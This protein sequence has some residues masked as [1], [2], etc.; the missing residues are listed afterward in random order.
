MLSITRQFIKPNVILSKTTFMSTLTKAPSVKFNKDNLITTKSDNT[1]IGQ[2]NKDAKLKKYIGNVY[3]YSGWGFTGSLATAVGA[4]VATAS[5]LTVAPTATI[6]LG[7]AWLGN[8]GYSFYTLFQIGKQNS[9][10]TNTM[11]EII[12]EKKLTNYKLFCISNGITIAPLVGV[13]YLVN[14]MIV[15][16]A[17]TSTIG[18]FAGATYYALKQKDLNAITWQAPLMGCVTGL[19]GSSLVQIGASLAGYSTFAHNLDIISTLI[20]TGVFTGL[21]VADTQQAIKDFESKSLDSINCSVNLL[22]DATN[23]FI[24]FIKIFTELMKSIKE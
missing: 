5:I 11:D 9:E 18:T 21:I 2:I 22:L 13:S 4:S 8:V 19:I 23:L 10:T 14:P 20:S 16:L 3:K 6:P 12:P 7:I 17:L 1:H 15:P 24:D